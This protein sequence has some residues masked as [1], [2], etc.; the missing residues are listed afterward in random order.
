MPV[1]VGISPSFD[2]ATWNRARR[3]RLSIDERRELL[4][5]LDA[6]APILVKPEIEIGFVPE[7]VKSIHGR[8]LWESSIRE[9]VERCGAALG[10]SLDEIAEV[11]E[12]LC[13]W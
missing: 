4:A 1:S 6:A 7:C 5:A 2:Y 10:L 12:D 3:G 8:D 13:G 9:V 11:T